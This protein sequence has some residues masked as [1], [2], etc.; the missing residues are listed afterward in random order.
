MTHTALTCIWFEC[1]AERMV[2]QVSLTRAEILDRA[3][4]K[5]CGAKATDMRHLSM[6]ERAVQLRAGKSGKASLNVHGVQW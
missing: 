1:G 5:D 3:V 2:P 4:C 6:H